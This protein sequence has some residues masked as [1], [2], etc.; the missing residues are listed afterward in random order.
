M[1]DPVLD[2]RFSARGGPAFGWRGNDRE[3]GYDIVRPAWRH[4]DYVPNRSQSIDLV[5]VTT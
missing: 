1:R 5:V 3:N 2:S 4:A